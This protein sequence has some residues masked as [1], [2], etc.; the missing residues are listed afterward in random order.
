MGCIQHCYAS[1]S[2]HRPSSHAALRAFA[3][4]AT[5]ELYTLT[6][7]WRWYHAFASLCLHAHVICLQNCQRARFGFPIRWACNA[8][9][10]LQ[11][12]IVL[13][14]IYFPTWL[15]H[16]CHFIG[17]HEPICHMSKTKEER[18]CQALKH[19]DVRVTEPETSSTCK[20]TSMM[21]DP[22]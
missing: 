20:T 10:G 18:Y 4:A 1:Q 6:P 12:P 8:R 5:L 19:R 7:V 2:M 11:H 13:K 17:K 3:K 16:P 22:W 21:S 9:R 14:G 15:W